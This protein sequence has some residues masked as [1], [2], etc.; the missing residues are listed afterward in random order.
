MVA[1]NDLE[2]H[3]HHRH[4][5]QQCHLGRC[6]HW[7]LHRVISNSVMCG[8]LD[9]AAGKFTNSKI[10]SLLIS[11]TAL[12]RR[13]ASTCTAMIAFVICAGCIPCFTGQKMQGVGRSASERLLLIYHNAKL[14][15][16]PESDTPC[17]DLKSN[18]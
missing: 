2:P 4:V 12:K 15:T 5:V 13:L 7:H 3:H 16:H 11:C 18:R 8:Q 9:P 1:D 14:P 17:F 10:K 6:H